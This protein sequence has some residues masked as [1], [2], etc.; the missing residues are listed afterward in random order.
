[1]ADSADSSRW[2]RVGELAT[3]VRHLIGVSI[4]QGTLDARVGEIG[5]ERQR[6]EVRRADGHAAMVLYRLPNGDSR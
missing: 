6:I 5:G 4:A 2:V 1:M 3:Y